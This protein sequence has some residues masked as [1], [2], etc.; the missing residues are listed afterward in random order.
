MTAP[1]QATTPLPPLPGHGGTG[2]PVLQVRDLVKHFPVMSKSV[3]RR[4]VGDVHV[5]CGVSF[6]L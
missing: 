2:E 3:I 4:R 1:A 6:D 5:V